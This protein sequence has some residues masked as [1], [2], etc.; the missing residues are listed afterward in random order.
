MSGET[1]PRTVALVVAPRLL[2]D[3]LQIALSTLDLEVVVRDAPAGRYDLA[4]VTASKA[5]DVSA[6]VVLC[7][8]EP[9]SGVGSITT[10][11]GRRE[12]VLDSLAAVLAQ[13]RALC[14]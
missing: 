5:G 6:D 8:P 14:G 9:G 11:E 1:R 13:V 4:V 3:T 12:V 2:S 10:P 7:L